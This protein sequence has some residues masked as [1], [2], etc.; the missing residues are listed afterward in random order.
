[1][2][3]YQAL[4]R[5]RIPSGAK[6][7]LILLVAALVALAM[8]PVAGLGGSDSKVYADDPVLTVY[9][10]LGESGTP[11]FKEDYTQAELDAL[12]TNPSTL[13]NGKGYVAYNETNW[14]VF[15]T[16]KYV[17]LSNLLRDSGVRT[18]TATGAIGSGYSIKISDGTTTNTYTYQDFN[19]TRNYYPNTGPTSTDVNGATTVP[20][21][22]AI[23]C[24]GPVD[25]ITTAADALTGATL[26][27]ESGVNR[28]LFGFSQAQYSA[29]KTPEQFTANVSTLTVIEPVLESFT[30]NIQAG[31]SNY[32]KTYTRAQLGA[33]SKTKPR[34]FL[35]G[36][37]SWQV[38]VTNNY[39]TVEDLLEDNGVTVNDV[40]SLRAE[41]ADG[42]GYTC[43]AENLNTGQFFYPA[44]GLIIGDTN[45]YDA[46]T[47]GAVIALDWQSA[48]VAGTAGST[49]ANIVDTNDWN[50]SGRFYIGLS[51]DNYLAGVAAGNRFVT[52]PA[53][54]NVV[55]DESLA[56]GL[57]DY[58]DKIAEI[59]DELAEVNDKLTQNEAAMTQLA[60]E[61]AQLTSDKSQLTESNTQRSS[62]N[63]LLS[64][65]KAKSDADKAKLD[66]DKAQ[67]EKEKAELTAQAAQLQ[68][69]LTSANQSAFKNLTANTGS[70]KAGKKKATV[71]WKKISGAEG[72]QIVYATNAKFTG[73]KT[74]NVKNTKTTI[75]NLKKGK[76]YYYKIRGYAKIGNT[77]VYT[78][79]SPTKKPARSSR[80]RKWMPDQVRHDRAW[81][82]TH[83]NRRGKRESTSRAEYK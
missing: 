68:Q 22:I 27:T 77:T 19:G 75:K 78:K 42:F 66:A 32:A 69:Q 28:Y 70:A 17:E 47:V 21:V 60:E 49:L 56:I 53:R 54:L 29:N 48:T 50:H 2:D 9:H 37:G 52:G 14:Q 11:T 10:Q 39:V 40:I 16:D 4:H 46:E 7:A 12:V 26:N 41:A 8:I 34:G 76:T 30:V 80:Q 13:G 61:I 18:G 25:I 38:H 79:Y 73:K 31:G 82:K 64:T 63:A 44:T 71:T 58:E 6:R 57:K 3:Y 59:N 36:G 67:L 20:P 43:S 62:D 23:D 51:E 33:L 72:Y 55:V 81:F 5:G 35:M 83:S 65:E 74:V 1:M 24:S 45:V 15:G